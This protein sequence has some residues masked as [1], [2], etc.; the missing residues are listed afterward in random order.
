[1]ACRTLKA[2]LLLVVGLAGGCATTTTGSGSSI[3][4]TDSMKFSWTSSGS[5]SGCM[6][7][8]FAN[9][10][11]FTG[12]FFQITSTLTDE[13]GSQGPIWHQQGPYDVGPQLQYVAHYTGRVEADLSRSDGA[14]MRCRLR[15]TRPV[16][17]MAG[18]AHGECQMPDGVS[19]KAQ[20]PAV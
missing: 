1:M 18:G 7:A 8:T 4:G 6:T 15:L 12:R 5:I 3:S 20:F 2:G 16:D 9:G 10:E 19:V 17:G 14:Q 11:T 13:L